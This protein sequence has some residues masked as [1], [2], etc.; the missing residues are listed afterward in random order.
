MTA[1]KRVGLVGHALSRVALAES[2]VDSAPP[3]RT[4]VF[5]GHA[6][7][8][9]TWVIAGL[10]TTFVTTLYPFGFFAQMPPTENRSGVDPVFETRARQP[11]ALGA[12]VLTVPSPP[13][14][15][16]NETPPPSG[17]VPDGHVTAPPALSALGGAGSMS[18]AIWV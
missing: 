16:A 6:A 1:R 15:P 18:A 3:L 8:A 12:E 5:D 13:G 10:S 9:P 4:T 14:K 2:D 7:V 11:S 17:T